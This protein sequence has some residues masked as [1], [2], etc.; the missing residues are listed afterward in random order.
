MTSRSTVIS[1]TLPTERRDVAL[2]AIGRL[3]RL[4]ATLR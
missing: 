2:E 4:V 3:S 1:R